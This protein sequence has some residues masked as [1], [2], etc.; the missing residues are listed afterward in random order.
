MVVVVVGAV[1]PEQ[2]FHATDSQTSLHPALVGMWVVWCAEWYL[3]VNADVHQTLRCTYER[4]CHL[5]YP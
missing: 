1:D 4:V 3:C 2:L 5:Q